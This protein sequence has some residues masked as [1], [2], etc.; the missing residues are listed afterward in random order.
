MKTRAKL[1]AMR[2]DPERSSRTRL[3]VLVMAE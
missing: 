1:S 2:T 3:E